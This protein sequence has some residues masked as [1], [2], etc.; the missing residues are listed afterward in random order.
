MAEYITAILTGGLV[1]F[2]ALWVVPLHITVRGLR[3]DIE[4]LKAHVGYEEVED[5]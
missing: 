4:K 1:L 5:R 3:E 2:V